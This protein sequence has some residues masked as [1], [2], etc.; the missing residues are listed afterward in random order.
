MAQHELLRDRIEQHKIKNVLSKIDDK[1]MKQC[2][3]ATIE[4][5]KEQYPNHTFTIKYSLSFE[6]ITS[7]AGLPLLDD[8]KGRK[9]LPD[10]GV[11]WMD[12]KYPILITEIKH[13]G[14]NKERIAEGKK[15]QATGNAI[16]RYGKNLMALQTMFS[17]DIILP[18][19]VFCWG[20]DFCKNETTVLAKLYCLNNFHPLNK[21]YEETVKGVKPHNIFYQEE[22]WPNEEIVNI[23]YT[24][25]TIY[26]SYYL[27]E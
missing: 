4:L 24:L 6:E 7:Y 19:A 12:N 20:S 26:I 5:L 11:I 9:I 18:A 13:Q 25:S 21:I 3:L 16:E 1:D 15:K 8:F 2:S 23:M 22:K 14:T 10:G 17:N 27:R